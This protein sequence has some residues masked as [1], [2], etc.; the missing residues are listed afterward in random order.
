MDSSS[1]AVRRLSTAMERT[2]RWVFSQ[3]VPSDI[4]IKVDDAT[5]PLHKFIL[6]AKS[7]YIR[8]K[9]VESDKSDLG[10]MEL[11][12]IPGGA[13]AFEKA[14][15]FCYG[16]NFEISVENVAALHCAAE[17]LEMTEKSCEGNLAA[18]ADEFIAKAALIT[19]SGAVTVLKSCQKLLPF[20]E[21]LRIVQRC[22]DAIGSKA[23]H[24]ANSPSRSPPD[25]WAAE[26]AMLNPPFFQKALAAMKARG[27]TPKTLSTS[28]AV[29]AGKSLPELL[30]LSSSCGR[31]PSPTASSAGTDRTTQRNFIESFIAILPTDHDTPLP[32]GFLCCLLRAAIFL[33][34]SAASRRDLER[35]ISTSLDQVAVGDLMAIAFDY[36]G[37]RLADLDSIRRIVTGFAEREVA[38]AVAQRT[39][40]VVDAF[41]AEIA[42]EEDLPVSK[43]A[44]IAGALSKSSRRFDDDLY[45]AVDIYL[46]AHSGLDE[47]E[48]EKA[49]SVMD[50]LRLSYEA[51]LHA[52]Q[53]KRLPLQVV[54]HALYYDQL[55]LRSGGA[56]D[57]PP[58]VAVASGDDALAKENEALRSELARMKLYLTDIQRSQGSSTGKST[59]VMALPAP[60][61]AGKK[62]TFFSSVSKKLG[63]LNPFRL[64]S[65]DT[66]TIEENVG[67]DLAKPRKRR[68][69]IS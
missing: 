19:L 65:K 56:A 30:P 36:S 53:N 40:R 31:G 62:T 23:T 29:Y 54:L 69:S 47:I 32:V 35:R 57:E 20:A 49:C 45:R 15:R 33:N 38:G 26:L 66:S 22:V 3:E 68:F 9:I 6:V 10:M 13:E 17:W 37:Q 24:E 60:P 8:K 4:V 21:K 25:W 16:V 14:A 41:V 27:A 39:A 44:G 12:G 51:R 63:K 11:K 5:F 42:T 61:V 52:S 55:K 50:P 1:A 2:G 59:T 43:F 34:S 58:V 67:V 18:R 28:V 64:G 7:G 46:K 48:R